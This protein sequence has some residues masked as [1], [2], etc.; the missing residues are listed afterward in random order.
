M[1]DESAAPT[2]TALNPA[3]QM[4]VQAQIET[5]KSTQGLFDLPCGYIPPLQQ[6]E[7]EA[8][9]RLLR[10]VHV[11]E[12]KGDVEDM[13]ASDKIAPARRM[14][15]LIGMCIERL[16]TIDH[17]GELLGTVVPD[18]LIGDRVFLLFCIRRVTLGD[19]YP[20][21]ARCPN[22]NCEGN[23]SPFTYTINLADTEVVPM[24]D[25]MKRSYEVKLPKSGDEVV[26]HPMCGRDDE[27]IA[28]YKLDTVSLS[29]LARIDRLNGQPFRLRPDG[30]NRD[31]L[32]PRIQKWG[33]ADRTFLRDAMLDQEGGVD[34]SL[35]ITCTGCGLEYEEEMVLDAGFFRPSGARKRS[36]KR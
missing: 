32:V 29:M 2:N 25:P 14:G 12:I 13:M 30:K 17:K 16:G 19:L 15:Q 11:R 4:A 21:A 24:P 28:P 26:F 22:P 36:K 20:F 8:D 34:T 10:D 1:S 33:L 3:A 31:L 7:T 23:K 27:L 6:G 5:P 18:L 9:R 35:Q